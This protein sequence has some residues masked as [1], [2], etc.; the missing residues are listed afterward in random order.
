[1][2]ANEGN[3]SDYAPDFLL[4]DWTPEDRFFLE[5]FFTNLDGH[6]TVMRNLPPELAGALCSKASRSPDYLLRAF[7][8]EYVY[9]IVRGGDKKLADDLATLAYFMKSLGN[10]SVLNNRKARQF[11]AKWLAGFGDDSIAQMTGS[12][13]IFW[14]ISQVAL[15]F[16]E[17][18]RVGLEPIEKSTRY[19]SYANMIGGK[20]LRERYLYHVPYPDLDKHGLRSRYMDTLNNLFSTYGH[21]IPRL[22]A[23]LTDNFDEKPTVIEKK[24][25]DT[26]RGLLPMATL[27]QVA[28]RGNAQAFEYLINRTAGHSLGELRWIADSVKREL[29]KEIPSLLLRLN[30]EKSKNYQRYLRERRD[31]VRMLVTRLTAG[32][33]LPPLWPVYEPKVRLVEYDKFAEDKLIAAI[34]F[35]ESNAAWSQIL[36]RVRKMRFEDKLRILENYFKDR[37][38]RWQKV[39][40]ALESSHLRFEIVMNIGAYRDLHRHRMH[41]QDRQSFSTVHGYDVPQEIKFAGLE[42]EFC[43]ALELIKPLFMELY[44]SCG[45]ELAQYAVPLAYRVRFY[46]LQNFR[47]LFWETE[48]RTGPQGHPDYRRIEQE[49]FR[50]VEARFPLIARFIKVDMNDYAFARRGAED[51]ARVKEEKL[52]NQ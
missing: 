40:R 39:G 26:L 34:A 36:K 48:L 44:T 15:K 46:Q 7:L 6:I 23:W 1:M 51:A 25:F 24:A 3:L 49:K 21:L 8:N 11:Y 29:D 22:I 4:E 33:Y 5:P 35:S 9:P 38:V 19:V 32:R 12:H 14:G 52:L 50:L 2:D 27:S 47:E 45:P 20:Y 41:T 18:Q 10:E 37:T 16:I 17:D 30:E 13:L 42:D 28:F 43:G 31:R